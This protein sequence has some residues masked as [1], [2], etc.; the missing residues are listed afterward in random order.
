MNPITITLTKDTADAVL[1]ALREH[2]HT[3]APVRAYVDKRYVTMDEAFRNRKIGEVQERMDRL[4]R[5][6]DRL[7]LELIREEAVQK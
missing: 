7:H 1:S 3:R 6:S 4:L 5:F 2:M